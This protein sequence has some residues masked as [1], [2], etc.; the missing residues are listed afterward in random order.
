MDLAS[1]LGVDTDATVTAALADNAIV[2]FSV[3]GGK[4]SAA[5]TL[6][7][8]MYLDAIGHDRARRIVIH[9]DLG[10]I[11]WETTPRHVET[12]AARAGLELVVVRRR[13]G[14]LIAR[15]EQRFANGKARYQALSTYGLI[16]PWSSSALRFCTSELKTHVIAAEL[17]RRFPGQTVLSVVGLRRD[18]SRS[19]AMTPISRPHDA[20][21]RTTSAPRL[22]NWHPIAAWSEAQVYAWHAEQRVPL[23]EAYIRWSASRM[24]C[25]FCVLASL[26]N[27]ETS[28]A[29]PGNR[30]AFD[31][32]VDLE[33]ASHFSFQ[34]NR[35]LADVAPALLGARRLARLAHAKASAE[36]RRQLEAGLPDGLRFQRG[37]PPRIPTRIEAATIAAVRV[38]ILAQ[39]ALPNHFPSAADVIDRFAELHAVQAAA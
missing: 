27:L 12:L 17:R 15:W 10:R 28:S 32:L 1:T 37:W 3:S 24:G 29:V 22:I 39:H 20:T 34:P 35:W 25:S 33:I 36:R 31:L 26:H 5:A 13:A 18:E 8:N 7:T 14:D 38:E 11:E 6:A 4:D 23:H 21:A 2:A 16:G 9:A 19:R 30:A